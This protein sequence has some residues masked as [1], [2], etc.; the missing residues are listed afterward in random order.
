M[1]C[2]FFDELNNIFQ[3]SLNSASCFQPLFKPVDQHFPST[4]HSLFSSLGMTSSPTSTTA[5]TTN[6][7]ISSKDPLLHLSRTLAQHQTHLVKLYSSI[8][9]S[10]PHSCAADKISDLHVGILDTIEAQAREAEKEVAQLTHSVN[11]LTDQIK[12]LRIRLGH[13]DLEAQLKI[14]DEALVPK[15]ER[16]KTILHDVTQIKFEREIQVENLLRRLENFAPILGNQFIQDAINKSNQ[17][18]RIGQMFGANLSLEYISRLEKQSEDCE[19]EVVSLYITIPLSNTSIILKN[20]SFLL[21]L[22][23]AKSYSI[24]SVKYSTCGAISASPPQHP[25]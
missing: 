14:P 17:S 18:L 13:L 7:S 9:H 5:T 11:E 10:D 19:Q 23:E 20:C 24:T 4:N 16:I 2:I 6:L 25:P 15:L 3:I 8:G 21:S 12:N 22:D 1:T